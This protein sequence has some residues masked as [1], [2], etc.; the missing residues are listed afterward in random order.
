M[1][2]ILVRSILLASVIALVISG[3]T[4]FAQQPADRQ[5]IGASFPEGAGKATVVSVCSGCHDLERL[6]AG[7]TPEGW[8]SVTT[9]MRNFGVVH[10]IDAYLSPA[11]QRFI[12][13]V[14]ARSESPGDTV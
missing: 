12:Q 13:I 6:T 11:T 1:R 14:Q 9:M 10:R 2:S 8:L 4:A 5:Q 7:Y 3:E